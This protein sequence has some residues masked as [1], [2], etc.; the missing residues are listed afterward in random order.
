MQIWQAIVLGTVQG[1]TEF[2][3]VSSSGH[4]VL[5]QQMMNVDFGGMDLLFD[6]LLHIGTLIAV[7]FVFRRQIADLV[8]HPKPKLFY[9][10]AASVPAGLVGV[11]LGDA[12]ERIFY[13]G[14]YLSLGFALS[15]LLLSLCERRG[16]RR[17]GGAFT[18]K[19]ALSMGAAQ[20]V[21]VLPGVSRSGSTIAVGLLAGGNREEVADFSF[22]MSIPVILGSALFQM[23]S[24]ARQGITGLGGQ[25]PA[26]LLGMLFAAVFGFLAIKWLL[27]AVKKGSYMPF[28]VYLLLLA[29]VCLALSSAKIL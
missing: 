2:L 23:I 1:L 13:G 8:L 7:F 29:V 24:V 22:L 17:A 6:I 27:R 26:L 9:L 12:I 4:L 21:A 5:L 16:K 11:L 28:V 10:L 25:L 14:A 15:A 19:H 3:P 18:W 20:A